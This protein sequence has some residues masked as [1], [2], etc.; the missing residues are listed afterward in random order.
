MQHQQ[1]EWRRIKFM[2]LL[3]EGEYL[4]SVLISMMHKLTMMH[5][6]PPYFNTVTHWA[7]IVMSEPNI[8]NYSTL[9]CN[10]YVLYHT[11]I[12]QIL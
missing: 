11:P 12:P 6:S 4:S 10:V 2:E 5:T 3:S 1:I 9:Y 8:K 7:V